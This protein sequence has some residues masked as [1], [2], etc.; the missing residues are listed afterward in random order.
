LCSLV[1][2]TLLQHLSV[3]VGDRLEVGVLESVLDHFPGDVVEDQVGHV[4]VNIVFQTKM[5]LHRRETIK[6]AQ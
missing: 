6:F 2:H 5:F 4:L 3:V 1:I